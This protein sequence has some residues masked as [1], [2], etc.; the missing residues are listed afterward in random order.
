MQDSS[1]MTLDS[2]IWGL[3]YLEGCFSF[4]CCVAAHAQAPLIC[5]PALLYYCVS[6]VY[7]LP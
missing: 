1:R 3:V 6:K 5:S 7:S 2:G 4:S